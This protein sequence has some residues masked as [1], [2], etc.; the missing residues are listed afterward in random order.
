MKQTVLQT[1]KRRKIKVNKKSFT[2]LT[3]KAFG[4]EVHSLAGPKAKKKKKKKK[5]ELKI[6]YHWSG[7]YTN[8]LI[9]SPQLATPSPQQNTI[10]FIC[11]LPNALFFVISS[12]FSHIITTFPQFTLEHL[13]QS[14]H[15]NENL[16]FKGVRLPHCIHIHLSLQHYLNFY[17]VFFPLI[18]FLFQDLSHYDLAV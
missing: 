2:A 16:I 1:T 5:E 6:Q 12:Y 9:V 11:E 10:V 8:K 7:N 17:L 15:Y 13:S 18:P 14:Y 4:T 3:S